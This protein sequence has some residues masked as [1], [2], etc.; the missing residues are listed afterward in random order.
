MDNNKIKTIAL[1]AISVLCV[2]L[3]AALAVTGIS[4]YNYMQT[5]VKTTTNLSSEPVDDAIAPISSAIDMETFKKNAQE[6]N[7][8]TEFVQRFFKDSIVY[9]DTQG[10]VYSPID[11]ALPKNNYNWNNLA[12]NNKQIQYIEGGMSKALKGI[13][14]SKHQLKIDWNKVK[15]DGVDFAIIR[16]GIRG[17]GTGKLVLDD[18]FHTNIKEAI[19]AGIKVGVY[20]YSQAITNAEVLEEAA[21][22]LEEIKK[23]DITYPVVFDMEEVLEDGVRT[24][25]LTTLE[26]TDM[27]IAF[28]E[29]IKA[30]GYTPMI[31]AN[32]KWFVAKL[33]MSR[34]TQYDK[35]FAQYY[36]QPF[37]PYEFQMWQYTAKGRVDGIE[38]NVDLNLSFKDYSN[39]DVAISIPVTANSDDTSSSVSSN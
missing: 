21:M 26:R 1:I 38:G 20:F 9:K 11:A 25:D 36:Q 39:P 24:K 27:T 31:Y 22:V 6:F 13:D 4:Y 15:N 7:L 35:W 17:Y 30:G 5:T 10:I 3:C 19:N 12:Y 14:V 33:D 28:C 23:Y 8:S 2:I 16:L 37:F 34:L 18:N 29:A 32:I